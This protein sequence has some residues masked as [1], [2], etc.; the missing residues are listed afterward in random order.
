MSDS[1]L[2]SV[3]SSACFKSSRTT[4]ARVTSSPVAWMSFVHFST[5]LTKASGRRNENCRD[6]AVVITT[7]NLVG[8]GPPAVR[9]VRLNRVQDEYQSTEAGGSRWVTAALPAP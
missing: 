6:A 2:Q 1:N 9:Q 7:P 5:R 4:S 8:I 3:A